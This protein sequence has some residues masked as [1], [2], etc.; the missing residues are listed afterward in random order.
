MSL[1]FPKAVKKDK[2]KTAP[3]PNKKSPIKR[4]GIFSE[5]RAKQNSMEKFLEE[6]PKS[7]VKDSLEL[8]CFSFLF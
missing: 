7:F 2:P 5:A 8:A 4:E 6:F 1:F 3:I